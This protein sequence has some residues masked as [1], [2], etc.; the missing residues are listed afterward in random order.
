MWQIIPEYSWLCLIVGIANI[1]LITSISYP[2][3][4]LV[5]RSPMTSGNSFTQSSFDTI[6]IC[7]CYWEQWVKKIFSDRILIFGSPDFFIFLSTII[8]RWLYE[9]KGNWINKKMQYYKN[10]SAKI[11]PNCSAVASKITGINW[12]T[13]FMGDLCHR[14]DRDHIFAYWGIIQQLICISFVVTL[15][16]IE[17]KGSEIEKICKKGCTLCVRSKNNKW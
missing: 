13:C 16:H 4:W 10:I 8:I 9:T 7:I 15:I 1:K 6:L 5:S 14:C 11:G 3:V 12:I 2:I 17:N